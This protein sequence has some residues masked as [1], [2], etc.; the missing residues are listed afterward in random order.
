MADET[1]FD[2][3]AGL[4]ASAAKINPRTYREM[5]AEASKDPLTFW[6]E[7]GRRLDWYAPFTRLKDASRSTPR[8]FIS[9]GITTAR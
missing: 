2:V 4:A 5:A 1:V 9:A 7:Q 6:R 3:P 8:I